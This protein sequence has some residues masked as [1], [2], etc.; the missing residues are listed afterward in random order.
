MKQKRDDSRKWNNNKGDWKMKN[1]NHGDEKWNNNEVFEKWNNNKAF[2][3]W[4]NNHNIFLEIM[5]IKSEFKWQHL[6]YWKNN[7]HWNTKKEDWMWKLKNNNNN[8]E[9][10]NFLSSELCLALFANNKCLLGRQK[11]GLHFQLSHTTNAFA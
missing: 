3:K 2:K 4:N 10:M 9:S 1:N 7:W 6:E 8:N 5:G 11:S